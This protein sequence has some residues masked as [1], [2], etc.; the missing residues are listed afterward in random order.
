MQLIGSF[1]KFIEV[2]GTILAI[3]YV[4]IKFVTLNDPLTPGCIKPAD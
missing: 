3:A 2:N 4:R 1:L